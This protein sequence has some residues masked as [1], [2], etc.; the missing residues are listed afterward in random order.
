MISHDIWFVNNP[1]GVSNSIFVVNNNYTYLKK[2][3]KLSSK[4]V[5][6]H[7]TKWHNFNRNSRSTGS[8]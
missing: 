4:I 8:I 5:D 3:K 2:Y 1:T 6:K 7:K